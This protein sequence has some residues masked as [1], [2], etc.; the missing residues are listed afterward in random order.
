MERGL[1]AIGSKFGLSF[2]TPDG[3]AGKPLHVII[4][5][6]AAG[7]GLASL[8]G[9][10]AAPSMGGGGIWGKLFGIAMDALIPH[11]GGGDVSPGNAYLVG[12]HEPEPF[13]PGVSGHIMAN[14]A[15]S[16]A[17]GGGDTYVITVQNGDPTL[18]RQGV[19]QAIQAAGAASVQT[20]LKVS[21]ERG[22]RMPTNA[23]IAQ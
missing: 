7:A 5:G 15:M 22:L 1:G 4:A 12:A 17:L 13:F 20:S 16:R 21:T 8:A 3:T 11:A 9:G 23:R 18:N 2:G 19:M 6:G 14:E 10:A